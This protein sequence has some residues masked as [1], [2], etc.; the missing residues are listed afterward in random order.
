[1]VLELL[2]I[3]FFSNNPL[4]SLFT[5]SLLFSSRGSFYA[6]T[7]PSIDCHISIVYL[8][9]Y[10]PHRYIFLHSPNLLLMSTLSSIFSSDIS[11][12]GRPQTHLY[13]ITY[14]KQ[15]SA[16][17]IFPVPHLITLKNPSM[18]LIILST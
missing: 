6:P 13:G 15:F 3:Y 8:A 5:K 2:R 10:S 4:E 16:T 17:F 9:E 7:Y 14:Q 1:M 11:N 18:L 12:I